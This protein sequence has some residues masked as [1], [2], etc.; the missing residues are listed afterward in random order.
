MPGLLTRGYAEKP[1]A[2]PDQGGWG[3]GGGGDWGGSRRVSFAGLYAAIGATSILFLSLAAAFLARRGDAR[4][5]LILPIPPVLWVN[6][7][8]LLASSGLL[9]AARSSL[10]SG[11]REAFNTYWT[12]ATVCGVLFLLGQGLVWRDLRAAGFYVA[13]N[14]ST[15]F[16]YLLTM[17]HAAHVVGGITALVY[18]DVEALLYELG[19]AKR[20]AADVSAVFWHFLDGLWVCLLLL[21][22]LWG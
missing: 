18:V 20:T 17:T 13:G 14:A 16:F 4:E 8:V 7:V 5:W 6:T 21:L 22:S 15:A 11:R 12:A 1:P 9:E 19:P 2:P 3:G 10:K